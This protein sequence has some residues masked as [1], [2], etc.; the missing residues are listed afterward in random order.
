M[1]CEIECREEKEGR[2]QGMQPF[3]GINIIAYLPE[4]GVVQRQE[5]E[6]HAMNSMPPRGMRIWSA[7]NGGSRDGG[8]RKSEDI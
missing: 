8:L 7:A 3:S 1:K 5:M 2:C 4:G 6:I